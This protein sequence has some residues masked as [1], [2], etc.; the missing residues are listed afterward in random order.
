MS[1]L[2][3]VFAANVAVIVLAFAVLAWAPV[4][5][6]RVARPHELVILSV[7]LAAMLT[8]DLVLLRR[9][10]GP[11]R[12]LAAVMSA[13]DPVQPGLRAQPSRQ[14]GREVVALAEALNAMLDRLEDERRESSWRIL[15]AQESERSRIAREL[16]DEVGQM[17]TAVALRAERAVGQPSRQGEA[18]NEI[19]HT[20]LQSIEDVHRIGRE[21]RP[22]ALDDLG[23]VSAL[24]ALC[25]RVEQQGS[26]RVRRELD[27]RLP[28]LSAE[29]EL[30]IYRVAQEA[31]TNVL[32]HAEAV[33]VTVS[34][35]GAEGCV[36]LVVSDDGRGLPEPR[37]EGGLGGMRERALLI[38]AD[39]EVHPSS[40]GGTEIVLTV[41]AGVEGR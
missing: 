28:A 29:V 38:H 9:A 4:T 35:T 22:E 32:R 24:I 33:E 6:H 16:H 37:R 5:V 39:L 23:L 31:L 20:V 30:V 40:G 21:L 11:L 3:R 27:W 19:A 14:A 34:L 18:L 36:V 7:G 13:V 25:S 8:G 2:W 17:L 15:A 12:A 26:V 10:F 1:L 41:P